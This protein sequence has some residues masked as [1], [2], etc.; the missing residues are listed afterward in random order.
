M[1]VPDISELPIKPDEDVYLG[2]GSNLSDRLFYL[3][4]ALKEL[5]VRGIL[6]VK[7]SKIWLSRAWG[8]RTQPDFLNAVVLCRVVSGLTPL[9]LLGELKD[10]EHKLGRQQTAIRWG[11]RKIDIDIL[12]IGNRV[13]ESAD[14]IVP[15]PQ[16]HCRDFV[17]RLMLELDPDWRHPKLNLS[18]PEM[19][20]KTEPHLIRALEDEI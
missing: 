5:E 13:I 4:S 11:P 15:H 9:Q 3:R 16:L 1:R 14:L 6:P 17:L 19:L 2:L 7:R 8:Y 18:I 20:E 10:I 12:A